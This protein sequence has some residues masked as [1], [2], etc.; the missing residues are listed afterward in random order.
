MQDVKE[1]AGFVA[2]AAGEPRA[3]DRRRRDAI[4]AAPPI[5]AADAPTDDDAADNGKTKKSEEKSG[6][7]GRGDSLLRGPAEGDGRPRAVYSPGPRTAA[8]DGGGRGRDRDNGTLFIYI[9]SKMCF[10]QL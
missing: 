3:L 8:A 5:T 6:V 4:A 2:G 7:C 1:E 10:W 9:S